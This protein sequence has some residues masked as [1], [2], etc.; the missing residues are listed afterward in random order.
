VTKSNNNEIN[1]SKIKESLRLAAIVQSSEDAIIGEA[2]DGTIVSWNP[3]AERMFGYTAEEAIGKPMKL[4]GPSE[5]ENEFQNIIDRVK[6]GEKI[7]RYE[8]QRKSK[9][10]KLIWV[11]VSVSAVKDEAGNIIGLAAID[12]DVT[13][14]KQSTGYA[15]SLIEASLDPLV[16]ISPDG[17]ITDVNEATIDVTGASR[18]KLIGTDFSNYFTEPN[19]AQEGYQTVLK[20]GLVKDYPLT[21][22]NSSGK[23]V[24]VLYNATVYKD[25][26]GKVLGV[27][28]AARDITAQKQASQYARSLI[29]ASLDPLVTIS[30]S[31]KITDVNQATI[32]ATGASREELIGSD[33]SNYFT[34]PA[35]AQEGY[36]Q[37][38]KEGFVKDYALTLKSKD[39][40]L[41]DVL[42]NASIYKDDRGKVLG[43][44]AA[45][46]DITE[47]KRASGYARSL[48]EASLDPLV[49]I[50]T[51]GKI[52]DVNEATIKVT[53]ATRENLIGADFANYFTNSKKAREGYLEAFK[54]GSVT[55]YALTIKNSSG[56]LV[57]VLYNASVYKDDKGNVL[58]VFAAARDVTKTKQASQY[59][60][61]LIEASVDPLVT[62]SADGKITDVNEATVQVTG[63]K[64]EELIGSDFSNYF[65]EPDQA[66]DGYQQV[67][68]L[69]SVK[70]FP[71]TIK[72]Q[73]GRLTDVLYNASVYKDDKGNVLGVFAAAR[74][75]TEQKLASQ[76]A[77]SLIEASL[78]PLVTISAEGKITDV[79]QATVKVTGVSKEVLVGSDFSRYFTEPEKA[80]QGYLEA[81]K[82]GEVRD[83]LL[84]I[85][86][87][88]GKITNVLYNASVYKD[89]KGNTLGVFAAAREI[90]KSEL[91]AAKAREMMRTSNQVIFKV[92]ISYKVKKGTIKINEKDCKKLNIRI[93]D[94]V[95]VS[96]TRQDISKRKVTAMSLSTTKF[97]EGMLIMSLADTRELGLEEEDT[98]IIRKAGE[99]EELSLV[100]E[101]SNKYSGDPQSSTAH[102]EPYVAPVTENAEN[103][104]KNQEGQQGDKESDDSEDNKK[105]ETGTEE[106]PQTTEN[107]DDDAKKDEIEQAED[108]SDTKDNQTDN[109]QDQPDQVNET[110]NNSD[111]EKKIDELRGN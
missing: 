34:E 70:D 57:D 39:A 67:F 90:G 102:P 30:P 44:F 43:L 73:N 79:N 52:T 87:V 28:A 92:G 96:P 64:R 51:E 85:R 38:Y 97:P 27:F 94:N 1:Q 83:Y 71:L 29:E 16:T 74:D 33:F 13:Q 101:Q 81:F 53:G 82:K 18:E 48:I 69:G 50:S 76:Y 26:K 8:T 110:Q 58:G 35:K 77:R 15:R 54:K 93:V 23:L 45:A 7:E 14:Q 24:D 55:D 5:R 32:D 100:K 107:T 41:I 22:K 36:R 40:S 20:K 75:I 59:A 72:H 95:T 10:G 103:D 111:F 105:N 19:K 9:D 42:Y 25:E 6:K 60:R 11:S 86:H 31:G 2:L 99:G 37:A 109:N 63:A 91:K 56:K 88:T 49:T 3:A 61:S 47:L 106:T 98:V 84:T 89:D 21:I 17:K 46:R 65:T 68:S 12:R 108:E 62:I 104:V 78:D 4:I 66:R 80:K